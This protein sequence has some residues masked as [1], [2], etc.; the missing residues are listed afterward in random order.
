LLFCPETIRISVELTPTRTTPA[1]L[2]KQSAKLG[3]DAW[4]QTRGQPLPICF[5]LE[6][7]RTTARAG[8]CV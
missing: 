3:R 2:G 5:S 1:R 4:L 8:A 7:A 6:S